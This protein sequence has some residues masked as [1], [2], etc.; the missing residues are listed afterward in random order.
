MV[1]IYDGALAHR[2]PDAPG[3]NTELRLLPPYSP[4]RNIVEQATVSALKAA[5]KADSSRPEIQAQ[6]NDREEARR[7]GVTVG[8][9]R[10]QLLLRRACLINN[11]T[12]M[13][14]VEPF[15]LNIRPSPMPKWRANGGL[16]FLNFDM[17]SLKKYFLQQ[18]H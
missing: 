6:M 8:G 10:Q 1:S 5:I 12:Q 17:Y 9:Y 16:I 15:H 3:A 18:D 13:H 7:Q 2:N 14:S 4:F 11:R